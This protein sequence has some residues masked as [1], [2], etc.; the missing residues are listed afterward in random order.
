MDDLHDFQGTWQALLLVD[1][2]RKRDAEDVR[3]T[4]VTV[5]GNRYTLQLGGYALHGVITGIDPARNH[6]AVDF[7]AEGHDDAGR[8]SL[9]VYVLED[10]ELTVC[11]AAP[12]RGRPTSFAPRR[13]SGH[14]LFLLRRC[15]PSGLRPVEEALREPGTR[16]G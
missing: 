4:R 9:G 7:V 2:G 12:G 1:D 10:D 8:K 15:A 16:G 6:G 11:V 5:T 3:R 14:S 13:G